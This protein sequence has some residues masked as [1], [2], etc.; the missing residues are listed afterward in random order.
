MPDVTANWRRD[1]PWAHVYDFLVERESLS[2]PIGR[3]VFGTD[4]GLLYR[5]L[6][7][8][9]EVPDGGAILDIPCGG[10]VALRGLR[11]DQRVRYVAA[12]VSESMLERTAREAERR[13]VDGVE[14]VEADVEALPFGDGEFDLALSFAGLHVFPRPSVA[15]REI[16]RCLRAGGSFVG[17]MFLTDAGLRY[18]PLLL[19]GRLGGLMGP[20]GGQ[21]DL[22][23]WMRDAGLEGIDVRRSGAVAYFS[24][25]RPAA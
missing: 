7:R 12:D 14:L 3:L 17:S 11:P 25:T 22:Q 20:S 1:H 6:E 10:G 2:R 16:A 15:V 8:V 21:A 23:R 4:T 5:T 18:L 19:A 13:G 9:S 24:A